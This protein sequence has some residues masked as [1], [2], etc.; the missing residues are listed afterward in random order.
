MFV[1]IT[2]ECITPE[3]FIE[4]AKLQWAKDSQLGAMDTLK[5]GIEKLKA[6]KTDPSDQTYNKMIGR[7]YLLLGKLSEVVGMPNSEVIA[8][9]DHAQS[10]CRDWEKGYF[11]LGKYYDSIILSMTAPAG[12]RGLGGHDHVLDID[13]CLRAVSNYMHALKFGAR[14]LFHSLP[15]VL[16]LWSMVRATKE[17]GP[18]Q[19]IDTAIKIIC[20]SIPPFIWLSSLSQLKSLYINSNFD[21]CTILFDILRNIVSAF[22]SQTIWRLMDFL[23]SDDKDNMY[24]LFLFIYFVLFFLFLCSRSKADRLISLSKDNS[25]LFT[26]NKI[27]ASKLIE[28]ARYVPQTKQIRLLNPSTPRSLMQLGNTRNLKVIMPFQRFL[29]P[30]IP[31]IHTPSSKVFPDNLLQV[32]EMCPEVDVM[33]S[34]AKPKKIRLT[35]TDGKTYQF[36][37]KPND[38]PRVDARVMEVLSLVNGMLR[39]NPDSRKRNFCT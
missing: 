20:P 36:L 34:L 33:S 19:K 37:C 29:N 11:F 22:P 26:Q 30:A 38:D 1:F 10:V 15:R 24:V 12:D 27:F 21:S 4:D 32:L 23:L 25:E 31:A 18:V 17:K 9:Y 13:F 7:G 5:A 8:Q 35:A 14:Y 2:R 6:L 3:W 39:V 28:L 16:T